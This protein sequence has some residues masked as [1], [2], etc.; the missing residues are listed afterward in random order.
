MATKKWV[1]TDSGN[2]GDWATA[3]NWDGSGVP[4]NG[5][6]VYFDG[7]SNQDVT[8]GFDQSAV[9][10]ASLNVSKEYTG[11]IGSTGSPLIIDATTLR[12]YGSG[13]FA[14]FSGDYPTVYIDSSQTAAN[15]IELTGQGTDINNLY[16]FKGR[17]LLKTGSTV[18][19]TYIMYRDS[20]LNDVVLNIEPSCTLTGITTLG[21]SG[22]IRSAISTLTQREG[23]FIHTTGAITT[24]NGYG[25]KLDWQSAT[26]MVTAN[27][28]GGT[29]D[30][31]N[32]LYP[33]T[34]TT[35]NLYQ[36][37]VLHQNPALTVTTLNTL[38]SAA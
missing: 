33:R 18:V 8:E 25:G 34:I 29:L 4:S 15:S 6:A 37:G 11:S 12:Y 28:F 3:A 19:A 10:L 20:K 21:G 13:T 26:T 23:S 22:T 7:S 17:V 30:T 9:A 35:A 14:G 36:G 32:Y 2:E 5:D 24:W 38:Q 1:G 27:I 16:I 31:R